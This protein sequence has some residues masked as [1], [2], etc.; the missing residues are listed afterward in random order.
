MLPT[1]SIQFH[2]SPPDSPLADPLAKV[3]VQLGVPFTPGPGPDEEGHLLVMDLRRGHLAFEPSL[4]VL[5]ISD[6]EVEG[7][8]LEGCFDVLASHEVPTRLARSARRMVDLARSQWQARTEQET[9]QTLN[10]IGYALSAIT[11]RNDLLNQ[12]LAKARDAVKADAGTLY[13][14][15]DD[16]QL[17]F[18]VAQ[19][20]TVPFPTDAP[21]LPVDET[22]LAG[23]CVHQGQMERIDDVYKIPPTAP[24]RWNTNF[25]DYSGYRT[26][27]MLLVPLTNRDG[28]V[29]GALALINRKSRMGEPISPS[30]PSCPFNARDEEL[31]RSIA[32][33]AAVALDN[34]RLYHEIRTLFDG[35]VEAAVT[36][37]EARDPT[38]GGHSKR[39]ARL[40]L[41]LARAITEDRSPAFKDVSFT[42]AD[43]LELHYAAILHDFGKVDVREQ[44]L[45]KAEKLYPWEMERIEARFRLIAAQLLLECHAQ[46]PQDLGARLAALQQDLAMVRRLNRPERPTTEQDVHILAAIA[47]RWRLPDTGESVLAEVELER[48][49][50]SRGSLDRIE[51]LETE[52]HVLHTWRFLRLIP[53]TQN[54]RNVPEIAAGHHEKLDGTGYPRG[55]IDSQ[56]PYGARLMAICDIWDAVTAADRP[57]RNA[58]PIPNAIELLRREAREGKLD[59]AAVEVFVAR[60]LWEAAQNPTVHLQDLRRR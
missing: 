29:I 48:L 34:F 18:I 47:G 53:W 42:D 2:L 46:S 44:V 54:L 15:G 13:L 5:A 51:R 41:A 9:V 4:R 1:S 50:I 60:H 33:Q 24:Y 27:S 39:V 6:A 49:K 21:R 10:A 58:M 26:H 3:A 38:T 12:I 40:T 37:I 8:P 35:F 56:I 52:E 32:A 28:N 20:E 55:L 7:T 17:Y 22:S 14:L 59:E 43:L 25:D 31:A 45:L 30:N 23:W 11:D 36:T 57:Y 16:H 19:N